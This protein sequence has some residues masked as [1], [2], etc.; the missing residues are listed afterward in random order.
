MSANLPIH[1]KPYFSEQ[2]FAPTTITAI[3]KAPTIVAITTPHN[4]QSPSKSSNHPLTANPIVLAQPDS[5]K[6]WPSYESQSF[7]AICQI[8]LLD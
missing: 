4:C 8:H 3:I 1:F 7:F 5:K 6:P 2:S